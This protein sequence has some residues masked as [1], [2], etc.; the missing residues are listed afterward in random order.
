MLETMPLS[1]VGSYCSAIIKTLSSGKDVFGL[2]YSRSACGAEVLFA[3]R[4]GVGASS[5]GALAAALCQ[6]GLAD[7]SDYT[8]EFGG[9]TLPFVRSKTSFPRLA[10]LTLQSADC[11]EGVMLSG[12]IK[13]HLDS[14]SDV[15]YNDDPSCG[16]YSLLVQADFVPSDDWMISLARRA[17][18]K[19]EQLTLLVAPQ[20]RLLGAAQI[21][22]RMNENMIFTMER[23]LGLDPACV[24]SIEGYAPVCPPGAKTKRKKL[25]LPDDYLHYGAF[26]RLTLRPDSGID[27]QKLAD[28]LAFRSLSIFGTLFIDLLDQAG[29]NFFKIPNLL[30]IN[31]LALVEVLDPES[32]RTCRAGELRPDLLV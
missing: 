28:E 20:S 12:P 24:A 7:V 11:F 27:A 29:G 5:G 17:G 10:T 2:T 16:S 14:S 23:S 4:D 21:A 1:K 18:C 8:A 26:S 6:G 25:L 30:H 9:K 32:G 3:D 15:T 19:P 13:L 22:G 31:K